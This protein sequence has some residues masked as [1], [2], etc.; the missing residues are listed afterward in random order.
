MKPE[1]QLPLPPLYGLFLVYLLVP[2]LI[3]G[4]AAFN[5]QQTAVDHPLDGLDR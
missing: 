1:P 2:L 4:G 5:D 3:M